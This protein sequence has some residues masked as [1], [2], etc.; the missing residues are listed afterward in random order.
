M[1]TIQLRDAK[2]SLSSV[3]AMAQRGQPTIITRHGQ[4][5]AMVVS[6]EEGQRLF[7]AQRPS[8]AQHLLAIPELVPT[9]RDKSTLRSVD[10]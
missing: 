4:P 9:E 5:S 7:P 3:V 8:L 6:M 2:A 1:Q 10:L